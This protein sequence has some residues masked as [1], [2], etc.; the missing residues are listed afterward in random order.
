MNKQT[1]RQTKQAKKPILCRVITD[2]KGLTVI[3]FIA[4]VLDGYFCSP[5]NCGEITL[6]FRSFM[7]FS[8]VLV[9]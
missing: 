9:L 1:N 6:I 5:E 7:N 3:L 8:M 2:F 4:T